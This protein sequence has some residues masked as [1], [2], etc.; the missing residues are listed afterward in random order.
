MLLNETTFG[1][2]TLNYIPRLEMPDL[3]T[4]FEME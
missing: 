4:D 2:I 1:N 3:I